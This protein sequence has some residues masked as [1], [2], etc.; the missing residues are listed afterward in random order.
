MDCY[1]HGGQ[2]NCKTCLKS[3]GLHKPADITQIMQFICAL[4]WPVQQT[5]LSLA[6]QA[7][8]LYQSKPVKLINAC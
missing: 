8:S 7:F 5:G 4:A 3:V 6:R 2:L 1:G